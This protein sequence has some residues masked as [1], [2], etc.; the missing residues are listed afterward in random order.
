MSVIVIQPGEPF[1]IS[2]ADQS[3]GW[4][5]ISA[6]GGASTIEVIAYNYQTGAPL[7]TTGV[8]PLTPNVP[9]QSGPV[10]AF[11]SVGSL[12]SGPCTLGFVPGPGPVTLRLKLV[13]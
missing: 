5:A 10:P 4:N 12:S 1:F 8:L 13:D 6:Y 2:G 11:G 7:A 3:A 9:G